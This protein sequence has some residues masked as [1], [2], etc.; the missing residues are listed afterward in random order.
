MSEIKKL[1]EKKKGESAE[2]AKAYQQEGEKLDIAI[3]LLKLCE[4]EGLSQREF[5]KLVHKSQS[6]I[7]RIECGMFQHSYKTLS[8]IA[9]SLDKK[10]QISFI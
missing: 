5:A 7:A 2:F 3:A 8:D 10:L 1:I 6:T 9:H 4:Q